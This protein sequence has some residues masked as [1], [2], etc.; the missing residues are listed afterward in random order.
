MY[1]TTLNKSA[2]T[3]IYTPFNSKCNI[4][5]KNRLYY[6]LYKLRLLI[7]IRQRKKSYNLDKLIFNIRQIFELLIKLTK[8]LTSVAN[9]TDAL[10]ITK[11]CSKEVI[12][13]N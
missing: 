6:V 11:L 1:F 10:F 12:E 9:I 8:K 5:K 4:K 3:L 2:C 13:I 7:L